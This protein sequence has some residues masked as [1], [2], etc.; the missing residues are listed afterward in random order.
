M[1]L[2][3]FAILASTALAFTPP[4]MTFAVGKKAPAKAKTVPVKKAAAAAKKV[5]KKVEKAVKKAAPVK[6]VKKAVAKKPAPVKPAPVKAVK[7]VVVKK[8][9][10]PVKKVVRKAA[11]AFASAVSSVFCVFIKDW[12][13]W[14]P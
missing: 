7:K 1:K 5:E 12:I 11:P 10:P 6:A 2:A 3:V 9:P 13:H 8:T 4:S 14:L